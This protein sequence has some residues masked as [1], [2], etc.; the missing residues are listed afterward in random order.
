MPIDDIPTVVG[1]NLCCGCGV[2]AY[3]QPG[4]ITMVDVV[5]QGRRPVVVQIGPRPALTSD[6]AEVCPGREVPR[7][8]L[9]ESALAQLVPDWGPVL[10]LWEGAASRSDVRFAGSSGGAATALALHAIELE[11]MYG[12]L[13]SVARQDVPYLN[14]T[15]MSRS[16]NELLAATGSRY[17]PASPCDGLEK[18]E[19]APAPCVFIG[20]PCDVAGAAAATRRRPGLARQLG[21]TIAVFCAGTPTTRGTLEMM[22][23]M[24]VDPADVASVRYRG[25]GWPGRATVTTRD[26][27]ATHQLSYEESWGDILQKHRQWR[28]Y[29]CADHTGEHADIS[30]G[31]PWYRPIPPGEPGLSLI[32][33]RT[34][35]GRRIVHAA[36]AA[37]AL[38]I[39][40]VGPEILLA[41]QPNLLQ[42][43]GSAWGR[44]VALR[45]SGLPAPRYPGMDVRATWWRALTVRQKA[46][47]IVGTLKRVRSKRLRRRQVVRP[48]EHE[49]VVRDP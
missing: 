5:D 8:T 9:P 43:R 27:N 3:V 10:E 12:V 33:V 22:E 29:V 49:S 45:L 19:L 38:D 35:R 4:E 11:G 34:E 13:H 48:I 23:Q 39:R 47:S 44:S 6:A 25:N 46:Q 21:L 26:G 40:R 36:K 2:C 24:G 14:E 7:P 41:S 15:V 20:K 42:A 1:K 31:D 37:G 17:A 32:V 18:V 16:R 28:C 30:V